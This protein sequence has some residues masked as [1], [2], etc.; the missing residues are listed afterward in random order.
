LAA[1]RRRRRM[2]MGMR[3]AVV[4]GVVGVVL[5]LWVAAA[6]APRQQLAHEGGFKYQ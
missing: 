2:G 5:L 6:V 4:V 3:G 1:A